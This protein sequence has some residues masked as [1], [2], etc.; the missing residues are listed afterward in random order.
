VPENVRT[1][2]ETGLQIFPSKFPR[3]HGIR[4]LAGVSLAMLLAA[5]CLASELQQATIEAFNHYVEVAEQQMQ[6][7]LREDGPFLWIDFRPKAKRDALYAQLRAGQFVI[8]QLNTEDDG[9]EVDIPEGMVHHWVALAF[10]PG[11][12]LKTA[13]AV[14][15]DYDDYAKIYAPEVRRSRI[16]G[17]DADGFKIYLQLYKDSPRRVSYNADFDVRRMKFGPDRI[18]SSSISTR[19]AQLEDPSQPDGKEY[20]VGQDSGYLWRMNDYWRYEQKDG[21][22]FMQVEA[23][24]LS[25]DVPAF[26]GWIVRPVIRKLARQTMAELLEANRRAM[27]N[28][29]EYAP[30]AAGVMAESA[31]AAS[32][33]PPGSSHR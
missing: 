24:T 11:A 20:P 14:L 32:S 4:V 3:K 5:S 7:S 29:Q 9:R 26:L 13:E 28:P 10:I 27:E 18:A 19:I 8:R 12:T 25:R 21:G 6:S 2:P 17:R 30:H 33:S 15:G 31:T 16:Y 1:A 23:I 22:V